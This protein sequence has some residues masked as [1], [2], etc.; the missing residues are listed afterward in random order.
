MRKESEGRY[1]EDAIGSI[2]AKRG[3]EVRRS[4]VSDEATIRRT[5]RDAGGARGGTGRLSPLDRKQKSVIR[6][7]KNNVTTLKKSGAA[8]TTSEIVAQN[9]KNVN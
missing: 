8:G 7:I 1:S 2:R 9:K 6:T 3:E 4:E 5:K